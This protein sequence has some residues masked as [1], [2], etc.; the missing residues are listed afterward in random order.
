MNY[1]IVFPPLE[2]MMR[3]ES[4]VSNDPLTYEIQE[5]SETMSKPRSLF[6]KSKVECKV[7]ENGVPF[8]EFK[9]NETSPVVKPF[10]HA[11]AKAPKT[12]RNLGRLEIDS[13]VNYTQQQGRM[14]LK[15]PLVNQNQYDGS[16]ESTEMQKFSKK[17]QL[18]NLNRT[19]K[20][21]R[22]VSQVKPRIETWRKDQ[23]MPNQT[24]FIQTHDH[25]YNPQENESS[26]NQEVS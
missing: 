2:G 8:Y 24:M 25:F 1:K 21:S 22:H 4:E 18:S 13:R 17:L 11:Y 12:V 3:I 10:N 9:P 26:I 19:A 20:R 5:F 6:K 16:G 23:F 14:Q 15:T 7:N